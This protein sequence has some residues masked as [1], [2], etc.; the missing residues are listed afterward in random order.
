MRYLALLLVLAMAAVAYAMPAPDQPAV[1]STVGTEEPPVAVCAVEEGSGRTT[2]LTVLST[3]DGP[4]RMTLFASGET[5][6]SLGQRTGASGSLVIPVVDVAAV[7][8]VGAL[9][10]M[11]VLSSAAGAVV[12]GATSLSAEACVGSPP[13]SAVIGGGSTVS[14]DNFVI[15]LMNPYAGEAIV[16][17]VVV[18]ETGVESNDRFE[19]VIVP[20]RSSTIIDF[21][22]LIPGRERVSVS[23]ETVKGRVLAVG[24]QGS[25]GGS[26]VWRAQSGSTSWFVPVPAVGS[27]RELLITTP[28]DSTVEYQVDVYG[29]EGQDE[30]FITGTL[31]AR[32]ENVISLDEITPDAL[33]I[34][35]SATAPV[36]TTL[37]SRSESG[38]AMTTGSTV[39]ANR[40][41][42]PGAGRPEGGIASVVLFNTGLEDDSF[43]VRALRD[44]TTVLTIPVES[45]ELVELALDSADGYLVESAGPSVVL[46]TATRGGSASMA[47]GVPLLDE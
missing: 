8:T 46:W 40:W 31:G 14:G 34:R 29:P 13:T 12:L 27:I 23:M 7:G 41:F 39:E 37:R 1:G 17:M 22:E 47:I 2:Q 32:G 30:A 25:E 10:E 6:G 11:P 43:Q 36:I 38:L 24:R 15:H 21:S 42:L 19:R 18:S 28:V 5:A 33:G 3:V 4:A 20:S 26:A 16:E 35:V 45:G 44:N 9:V